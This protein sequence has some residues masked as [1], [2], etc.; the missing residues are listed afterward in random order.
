MIFS[1]CV[2]ALPMASFGSLIPIF[3]TQE[4]ARVIEIVE[5]LILGA[6]DKEEA[7]PMR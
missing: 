5:V 3:P 1:A 2:L 6:G 7:M 4:Q